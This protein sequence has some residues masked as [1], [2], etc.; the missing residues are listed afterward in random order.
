VQVEAA[1]AI[2]EMARDWGRRNPAGPL[3]HRM[4]IEVRDD[5]GPV[6]LV[7]FTFEIE[8]PAMNNRQGEYRRNAAEDQRQT[9]RATNDTDRVAWLRL[10]QGWL[11]LLTKHPQMD[12][13][14]FDEAVAD[15]GTGQE[16]SKSQN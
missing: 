7:K 15:K 16:Q 8:R 10:V 13:Q 9:H 14:S 12:Q 3:G 1:R 5:N 11:S 2:T 4:A 6:M